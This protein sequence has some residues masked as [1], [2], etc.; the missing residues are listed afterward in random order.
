MSTHS[1]RSCASRRCGAVS[2]AKVRARRRHSAEAR[3]AGRRRALRHGIRTGTSYVRRTGARGWRAL[4]R[5]LRVA[6]ARRSHRAGRAPAPDRARRRRASR[7]NQWCIKHVFLGTS[8]AECGQAPFWGDKWDKGK[9]E[10]KFQECSY[11]CPA[12]A[13]GQR[14]SAGVWKTT[15]TI[16]LGV[17]KDQDFQREINCCKDRDFCNGARARARS[18]VALA[19]PRPRARLSRGHVARPPPAQLPAREAV[20]LFALLCSRWECSLWSCLF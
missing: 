14:M 6:S 4:S 13:S 15:L 1:T 8:E 12:I 18:V 7:R 2:G 5:G 3:T 20:A 10:C 17:N 9:Q 16:Y 11:T 19:P